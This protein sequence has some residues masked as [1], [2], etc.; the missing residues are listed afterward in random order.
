MWFLLFV[1]IGAGCNKTSVTLTAE[2]QLAYDVNVIDEYLAEN[3]INAVKLESGVRYIITE[4]GTGPNPTKDNCVIFNSYIGY[5]L[6]N[7]EPFVSNG[8]GYKI[9][10]KRDLVGMQIGLKLMPVG[11]KGSI[12]IPSS[13]AYGGNS[14]EKI[15]RNANIRFDVEV[16]SVT[17][18]NSLGGY[19]N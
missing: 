14:D 10:L 12:F 7:T 18:F 11:T 15:P 6:Y 1:V 4:M 13:F 19:C 5:V 8:A 2:E 16:A 17:E 9:P 3:S